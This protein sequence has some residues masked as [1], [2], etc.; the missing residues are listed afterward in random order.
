MGATDY[1]SKALVQRARAAG[2][3]VVALGRSAT[4]AADESRFA[5][6]AKTFDTSL[7][8]GLHAVARVCSPTRWR[9]F[10]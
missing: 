4:S 10:C 2:W 3:R 8:D 6:L 9:R 7:L 5:D 1:I